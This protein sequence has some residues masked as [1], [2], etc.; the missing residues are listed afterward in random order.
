MP[1]FGL[2]MVVLSGA[3]LVGGLWLVGVGVLPQQVRLGDALAQLDG[4]GGREA[5]DRDAGL[6]LVADQGSRLESLGAAFYRRTGIPLRP[7][8]A[9]RLALAGRSI[10]DFYVEK[11]VWAFLGLSLPLVVAGLCAVLDL[12]SPALPGLIGAGGLVVG[13]FVPD[14]RLRKSSEAQ[15]LDAA[16]ALSTLFDL[17]T[18]E[19]LSNRSAF[20]AVH[21][22][23][24]LSD[25][26]VFVRVRGALE[27][28]RLQQRQPWSDLRSLG[29]ELNLPALGDMADVLQLDEQGATLADA[30]RARVRELR[31]AHLMRE[32]IAAQQVSERMTIWMTVPVLVFALVFITPPLLRMAGLA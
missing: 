10:G 1:E 3:I 27:N 12:P 24:Q 32:K 19:R 14:L 26:P 6:V 29:D 22:A 16:E 2:V 4:L 11:L 23:A 5:T 13:F 8:T 9:R 18:L 15:R 21:S 17:V 28:A 25:A 31:D 20:Q 30:L 7:T